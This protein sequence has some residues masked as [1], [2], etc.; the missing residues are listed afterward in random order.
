MPC[1]EHTRHSGD[2]TYPFVQS[3]PRAP[4]PGRRDPTAVTCSSG[5]WFW[6]SQVSAPI[7]GRVSQE[8]WFQPSLAQGHTHCWLSPLGWFP[9]RWGLPLPSP[10]LTLAS[11]CC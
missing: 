1:L 7:R 5:S 8:V 4:G 6:K 11:A 2:V 10:P 3:T 9:G